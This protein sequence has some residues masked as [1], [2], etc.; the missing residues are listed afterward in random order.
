MKN[1]KSNQGTINKISKRLNYQL[2]YT[3]SPRGSVWNAI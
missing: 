3:S 1:S 2:A